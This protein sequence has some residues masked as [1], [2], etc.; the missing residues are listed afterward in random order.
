M[1]LQRFIQL[2][3]TLVIVVAATTV[4]LVSPAAVAHAGPQAAPQPAAQISQASP[5]QPS[6][7]VFGFGLASSLSDPTVGYPSWNF[8]LLSTVAFFGL[9]INWDG[10]IVSD[11]GLTVWNSTTLTSLLSTAHSNGTKVVLTIVLQDFQPGTPNMCA[12]LINRAVTVGQ[13]VAQVKAKGVDG[14]NVDYEGLNGTCQNGQ[15]SQSMM[16]DFARQLRAALPTGSYL[17]VDTYASSAADSLGFFDIPGLNAYVDSFF[18]MAYD[19]EYSNYRRAPLGCASFCLGPTAPLTG[20]YYNDTSTVSQY[21]SAVAASKVILGVPYYGRKGCVGSAVPNGY[22]NGSVGADSY[23]D[24]ST[25]STAPGVQGGSY[26]S[27]RD[28]NDPAGQE[29]WDTWYNTQLG[30]TRELYFDDATSLGAKYDLVNRT[31]VRGVGIWTLN[32]GG[33]APELWASLAARFA[34]CTGAGLSPSSPTQPAGST[35]S[36]T[37]SATGCSSPR[38]AFWL[39]SPNGTWSFVQGFGGPTFTWNTAGLAP[40]TYTV[41]VWANTQGSGYEAVGS[42]TITL[43]GCTAASLS[44]ANPSVPANSTGTYTATSTGCLSPRYAFWVQYPGGAWQLAR[45]FGGPTWSWNTTGLAPGVYTVHVWVNS[46]GNGYESIA[47]TSVTLTA[48]TSVSISP[49]NPSVPAG[50][51]GTYTAS[52]TG[53]LSPRY[54]FWVQ[55]PGGAWYLARGFGGPTWSWNTTGLAPGLYTVHVWVNS[56][57]E[58]Y[59][60][61]GSNAVTLTG[62]SNPALSPATASQPAGS[63]VTFAASSTG[64]ANPVY[65]YWAQYPDGAWHLLRGFGAAA[66]AWSTAGLAAGTY[67]VH[68]WA[69]LQGAAQTVD[70]FATSTVTLIPSCTSA[71]VSPA[72]GSAAAGAAKF[73]ATSTGCTSP[74]Y[75]F[76]L[77]DPAGT[78]HVM[79]LFGPAASWT[80]NTAGWA[81]GTYTIHVWADQQGV[82][83]S[84]HE[85]I[86]SATFTLT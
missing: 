64:C 36:F 35:V 43:T 80:W 50:S 37:A 19:L 79:Q 45:G 84:V 18:V 56:S 83:P 3:A 54:A 25:E 66:F 58:G 46:S 16:T 24:A 22:P 47:S 27:H 11:S 38:Y 77:L 60:A 30:C 68:A 7:E 10:T 82:D 6:R 81:R 21:V 76:W 23:L 65:E 9:H 13:A 63:T 52:S 59:E 51:T 42:S 32:Y 86:G 33:S 41:H 31:G 73:T 72:T 49:A 71:S 67:T 20:Y 4:S 14:L 55:Y 8:S 57:G 28:A 78:W 75:E 1:S 29:R 15:T 17:S 48:C 69:N 34:G 26:A 85:A 5:R 53:C 61:I 62:C 44:P 40:G 39:Q 2:A 12:G 74:V 70:V